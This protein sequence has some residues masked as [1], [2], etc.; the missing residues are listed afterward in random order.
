M[1]TISI[2]SLKYSI[3]FRDADSGDCYAG[4]GS[5]MISAFANEADA[6]AIA[7]KFNPIIKLAEKDSIVFPIQSN[8]QILKDEFGFT[9]HNIDDGY[10]F[11]LVVQTMEIK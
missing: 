7:D 1:K 8:N 10:D 9:L 6:K 5:K 4:E 11:E 2:L 3:S